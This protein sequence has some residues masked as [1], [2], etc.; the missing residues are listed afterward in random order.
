[1]VRADMK[2]AEVLLPKPK[3]QAE[4][5]QKEGS[6]GFRGRTGITVLIRHAVQDLAGDLAVLRQ[7]AVSLQNMRANALGIKP[8]KR[9]VRDGYQPRFTDLSEP[10]SQCD[11]VAA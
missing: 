2:L 6:N 9:Y 4:A 5:K 11:P 7:R 8:H 1:M 3:V 10:L